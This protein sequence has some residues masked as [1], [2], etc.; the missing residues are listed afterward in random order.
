MAETYV[1]NKMEHQY[2]ERGLVWQKSVDS[3]RSMSQTESRPASPATV[4]MLNSKANEP[5]ELAF[6]PFAHYDITFNERASAFFN[7]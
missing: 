1:L 5:Q 3:E 2:K 7:T 6:Y 4:W